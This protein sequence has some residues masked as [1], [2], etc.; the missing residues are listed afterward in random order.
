VVIIFGVLLVGAVVDLF[1]RKGWNLIFASF[2]KEAHSFFRKGWNLIFA[3][4]FKEAHSFFRDFLLWFYPAAVDFFFNA[5]INFLT[6][7]FVGVLLVGAVVDFLYRKG[8]YLV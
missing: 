2:F 7:I 5:L 1:F 4:F 6:F 3:S 8:R